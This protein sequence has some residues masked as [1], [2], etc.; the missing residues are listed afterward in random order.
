GYHLSKRTGE[1]VEGSPLNALSVTPP[2]KE[3]HFIDLDGDKTQA[4]QAVVGDRPD[5]H[6]YT[7]NCNSILLDQVFPRV[8]WSHRR[9]ALC[10]LDPYGINL[11][12]SVVQAAGNTRTIEVFI[13]F[14][15]MDMNRNVLWREPEKVRREQ[16][17]RMTA[18]WGDESW[19]EIAYQAN[20]SLFPVLDRP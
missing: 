4:L 9:R 3:Y 14:M 18:F 19:T 12:W 2:F 6:L 8:R 17:D 11:N 10:L 16:R 5:V 15:V 1:F 13:N 7:G 20:P